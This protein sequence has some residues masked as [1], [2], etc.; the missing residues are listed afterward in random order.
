MGN[1]NMWVMTQKLTRKYIRDIGGEYAGFVSLQD[2]ALNL[3]SAIT[4]IRW[5]LYDKKQAA[6]LLPAAG[7]SAE[8]IENAAVYGKIILEALERNDFTDMQA[9]LMEKDAVT[10]LPSLYFIEK[11]GY[12]LWG[13]WARFILKKGAFNDPKRIPYLRLFCAYL[14]FVLY[15]VSPVGMIFYLLTYPFRR[16]SLRRAKQEMCYELN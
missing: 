7:V 6:K 16:L 13:Q 9:K 4:V 2:K 14:F 15:V 11:N 3:I 12:R 8:D 1:R 5:L 10:F